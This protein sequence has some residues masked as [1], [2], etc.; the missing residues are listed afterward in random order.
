MG[1]FIEYSK[2]YDI[3]NEEKDY[4]KEADY[5][6]SLVSNHFKIKSPESLLE[7]GCGT[8]KHLDHLK[9]NFS[10]IDAFDRSEEMINIAK[11]NNNDINYFCADIND[12]QSEKKYDVIISLFHVLSYQTDNQSVSRM[13]EIVKNNLADGGLFIFDC[14]YGPAVLSIKPENRSRKII[15]DDFELIRIA[16]PELLYDKNV[17]NVNYDVIVL[18][19]KN[20][21]VIRFNELHKMRY[22]FNPEL[23]QFCYTNN[24]ELSFFYNWLTFNNPSQNDWSICFGGTKKQ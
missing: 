17:V 12:F 9:T 2:Y 11:Q 10:Q 14:W 1:N 5:I 3:L 22:F 13:F 8:G 7:I 20:Q 6:L 21:E 15:K 19:K 23:Q 24:L 16:A 4:K 18:P